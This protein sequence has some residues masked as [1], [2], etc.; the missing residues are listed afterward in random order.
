MV[1][2]VEGGEGIGT[3]ERFPVL[4]SLRGLAALGVVFHHI[5]VSDNLAVARWD[6]NFN[7]LL[8]LFFVISGFVIAAAYCERLS[9]GF[10]LRRFL[11]LRISRI[12]PL[13]ASMLCVFILSMLAL[14]LMRPDLRT[15][16]LMA[17]RYDPADLP[18]AILLLQGIAP[19][20]GPVWN[21]PS[22]S[23]SVEMLL[24]ILAAF[25]WRAVGQ[26]A[27]IGWLVAAFVLLALTRIDSALQGTAFNVARGI[28]GFGLGLFVQAMLSR[29]NITLS[30]ALA[31]TLEAL[32]LLALVLIVCV[33]GN[34]VLFDGVAA[35][36][37]ALAV[38]QRGWISH[39]LAAQPF[40]VLGTLSYALYLSHVF[41]IGRVFDI[42]AVVQPRLGVMIA[43]TQVGGQ[44]M[45]VGPD[46]LAVLAKLAI[47]ALC[48]VVAWPFA[49]LIERPARAWSRR[50]AGI[51]G[52]KAFT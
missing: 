9:G 46:A 39:L 35:G 3:A 12:W 44:D 34:L 20:L 42:L 26:K 16:G 11:W 28:S 24:Y 47:A 36:L 7:L 41:V 43:Q 51:W 8:D 37:V 27:W 49:A 23:I 15:H 29:V 30:M 40:Q 31:T 18:A 17:G 48:L 25:G 32:A 4:D 45:L 10:S 6:D 38:L 21:D 13:H 2:I 33:S 50:V 19:S 22:W 52:H 5:P 14:G 1:T